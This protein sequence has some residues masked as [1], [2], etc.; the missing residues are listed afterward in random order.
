MSRA[1]LAEPSSYGRKW[2]QTKKYK[3]IKNTFTHVCIY[4]PVYMYDTNTP[5]PCY[6][7][8]RPS[9]SL[10]AQRGTVVNPRTQTRHRKPE[11]S[12]RPLSNERSYPTFS[13]EN[14]T[15]YIR[16]T[17]GNYRIGGFFLPFKSRTQAFRNHPT[18]LRIQEQPENLPC[19]AQERALRSKEP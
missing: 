16:G 5:M 19:D 12:H 15:G 17:E 8:P 3:L 11:V 4:V 6:S 1:P 9:K 13:N 10:K 2:K 14:Y 18:T 7:A